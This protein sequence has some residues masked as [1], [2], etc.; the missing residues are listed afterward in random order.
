MGARTASILV[1][2]TCQ[3]AA[4]AL[5]F[6]AAAVLP[7]VVAEFSLSPGHAALLSSAVQAG[8][9]LGTLASAMLG[10]A[11][12]VEPRRLF[13]AAALLGAC[14]NAALLLVPMDSP[15]AVALR[16]VTGASLACVY[17]VGMRM[18]AAWAQADLGLLI[19]ILVGALCLGSAAPHLAHAL[20]GVEWRPTIVA[21]SLSALLAA[22]LVHA[23][24]PGPLWRPAAR[25]DPGA[26]LAIFRDPA[27]R[28]ALAGYLGHMWEIYAMWAW[29][30]VFLDEAFRA[31]D[32]GARAARLVAF[33]AI[34]L[35]GL[36]GC[37]AGGLLAD[38]VGRTRLTIWSMAASGACAVAAGVFADAPPAVISVICLLWGLAICADSAQFSAAIAELSPPDRI[39]TMLTVQTSCGFLLTLATVQGLPWAV[40]A[41]GWGGAFAMLAIGPLFGVAAMAALRRRPESLRLAGGRR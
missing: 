21:T 17:P 38:R 5:W 31:A 9:V 20:G 18:V 7:Q 19:G 14:S 34:G 32:A 41:V 40:A 30:G 13:S 16:L 3:V 2:A 25:F 4:L 11:D 23:A 36:V 1:I 35:G 29:L 8:F 22:A 33:A 15:A 37:V 6:S 28:L 26:M 27:M 39:G 24:R 12:R 10:L